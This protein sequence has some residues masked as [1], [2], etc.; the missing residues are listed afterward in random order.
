MD[1]PVLMMFSN[2]ETN[3]VMEGIKLGAC[4]YLLKPV[5]IEELKD[6][7]KHAIRPKRRD[8]ATLKKPRFGWFVDLHQK[9]LNAVPK[10][11]LEFMDVRGLTRENVASHLQK[12]RLYPKYTKFDNDLVEDIDVKP[13]AT[14]TKPVCDQGYG[15][16]EVLKAAFLEPQVMSKVGPISEPCPSSD[17][18]L[19]CYMS[20]HNV[21][22]SLCFKEVIVWLTSCGLHDQVE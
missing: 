20:N 17:D 10:R 16:R 14:R 12:Y 9:F 11:I 3:A 21:C 19:T 4:D 5:M 6:I 15:E 8:P 7:W 18:L 13:L 22:L 2:G 1:L